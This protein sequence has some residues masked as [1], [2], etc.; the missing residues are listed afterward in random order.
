MSPGDSVIQHIAKVQN[1]AAQLIDVGEA[2]TEVTIMAK[3]LAS[4]SSKYNA[5]QTAWDSVDPQG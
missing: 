1:M 3:I 5:L 4:L 2:V